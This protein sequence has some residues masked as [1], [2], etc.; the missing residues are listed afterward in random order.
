M[1]LK[2][3]RQRRQGTGPCKGPAT[4]GWTGLLGYRQG[5]IPNNAGKWKRT[6]RVET[7]LIVVF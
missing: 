3:H 7:G 2:Q 4:L 1:Q 5:I 6:W